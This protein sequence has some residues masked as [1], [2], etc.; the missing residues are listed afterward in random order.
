MR[1]K[2]ATIFKT[3]AAVNLGLNVNLVAIL[4]KL[5]QTLV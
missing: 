3:T 1:F 4:I 5:A 2:L